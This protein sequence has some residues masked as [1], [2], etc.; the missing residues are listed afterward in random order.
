MNLNS[1]I[2]KM[3]K[4]NAKEERDYTLD[5]RNRRKINGNGRGI[6]IGYSDSH[7]LCFKVR[8]EKCE[9]YYDLDEIEIIGEDLFYGESA[10]KR[11]KYI[12]LLEK[13]CMEKELDKI[14]KEV[15]KRQR[16]YLEGYRA[17]KIAR[18]IGVEYKNGF[19]DGYKM[20]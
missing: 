20:K 8:G 19:L 9:A 10:I 3:V 14:T 1:Y 18:A 16:N 7:G 5:G 4:Y 11:D 12:E 15:T 6:V 13:S 17:G 2:G